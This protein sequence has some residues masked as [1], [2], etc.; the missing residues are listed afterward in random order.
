MAQS[1]C[2]HVMWRDDPQ[3]TGL[4]SS[5]SVIKEVN[6]ET[7]KIFLLIAYYIDNAFYLK[8]YS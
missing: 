2:D 6:F 3:S 7:H 1:F 4:D 5:S 8:L